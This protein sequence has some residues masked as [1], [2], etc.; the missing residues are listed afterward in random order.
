MGP[1]F[2]CPRQE[3]DLYLLVRSEL[4]YPLSYGDKSKLLCFCR[5]TYLDMPCPE[6]SEGRHNEGFPGSAE[7]GY[8]V[9]V[10]KNSVF[11]KPVDN[12]VDKGSWLSIMNFV[13]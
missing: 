7:G 8:L 9:N 4:L 11:C 6:L 3:L 10:A 13:I 2:L 1:R 5:E 12:G